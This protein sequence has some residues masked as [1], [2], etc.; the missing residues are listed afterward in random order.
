MFAWQANAQNNP[1][2]VMCSSAGDDGTMEVCQYQPFYLLDGLTGNVDLGGDWYDPGN[3]LIPG[4]SVGG[5]SII[6]QY[7]F[8]YIVTVSGCPSDTSQVTVIVSICGWGVSELALA[9]VSLSPNPTSGIVSISNE[10]PSK[11]LNYDVIDVHGTVIESQTEAIKGVE[12]TVVDLSKL[13]N[14]LYFIRVYNEN[15]E[16]TF[17]V[18]KQ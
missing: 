14:G 7:T 5:I 1:E 8:T 11:G 18:V 17:R 13:Q 10:N 3:N 6:G 12:T 9:G 2:E 4:Q 16:R 15:G